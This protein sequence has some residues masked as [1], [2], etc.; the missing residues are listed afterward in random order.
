MLITQL[1]NLPYISNKHTAKM[2]DA[3]LKFFVVII[4]TLLCWKCTYWKLSDIFN[5]IIQ[6]FFYVFIFF[7]WSML[8]IL[9]FSDNHNIVTVCSCSIAIFIF[10]IVFKKDTWRLN[11]LVNR[12]EQMYARSLTYLYWRLLK[13]AFL[14]AE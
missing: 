5:E 14:R 4:I 2:C 11:S 9:L 1:L 12:P 6:A 3:F 10:K 8:H 13:H 7:G